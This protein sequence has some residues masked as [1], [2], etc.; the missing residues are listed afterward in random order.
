MTRA[1]G[2]AKAGSVLYHGTSTYRLTNILRENRLCR[3]ST[4]DDHKVSLTPDRAVA[5]YFADIAVFG[6]RH[7]H[8]DEDSHPVVVMLDGGGLDEL[9][10]EMGKYSDPVWGESECDWEQE[11]AC[12]DDIEPLDEVLIGIQPLREE[13]ALATYSEDVTELAQQEPT[14]W[15]PIP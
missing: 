4:G 2:Q 15:S 11:I 9:Q 7:D 12:W 13:T 1:C 3:S 14:A 6:D 8:P 10:Y 5:V